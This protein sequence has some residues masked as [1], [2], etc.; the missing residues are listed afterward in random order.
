MGK[1]IYGRNA[2][3]EAMLSG[4]VFNVYISSSIKD[5][6]YEKLAKNK[7]IKIIYKTNEELDK[8]LK[9]CTHQGI[10]G[11]INEYR[12][13]ELDEIIEASKEKKYP[14]VLVLDGIEDPHNLGAIIRSVDAFSV[15]GII[16]KTKGQVDVNSTVYKVSTGVF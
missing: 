9:T 16:M 1:F 13:F 11:E 12:F 5:K 8:M 7:G 14:L 2:V 4:S 10:A 15:D 6:S 3:R